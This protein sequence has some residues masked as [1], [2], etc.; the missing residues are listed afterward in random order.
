MI[1][2]SPVV[3]SKKFTCPHC[4]AISLQRWQ[5]TSWEIGNPYGDMESRVIRI[6]KCDHCENYSLWFMETMLY[7]DT[8]VAPI[9]NSHMPEPV[10]L[11]Y[12]EAAAIAAKSPRG[13]AALLRLA[14]QTLCMELGEKGKNI[15]EDISELVK[16]G[17][18]ERIQQ[19]LD[20]VRVTGNNAVHPGKIDVDSLDVAANLFSLINVIIEYMITMP[21][22][23]ESLY[24]DLPTDAHKQIDKRDAER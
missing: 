22:K 8:G 2:I 5:H 10:K 13:A 11:I 9:P 20:I 17:L 24:S 6:S 15:N 23:I 7:P 14:L 4:G 18:P 16:K 1:Y 21:S 3:F 19:A 12:L